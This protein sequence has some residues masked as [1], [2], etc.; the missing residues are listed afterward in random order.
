MT[1]M[2]ERA[3]ALEQAREW[4]AIAYGDYPET[5]AALDYYRERG[6]PGGRLDLT[7]F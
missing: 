6:W 5:W 2:S 1:D 7:G 4:Q 3:R